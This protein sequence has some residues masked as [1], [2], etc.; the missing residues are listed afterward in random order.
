M[1]DRAE[2]RAEQLEEKDV[3]I[4]RLK[5]VI[6]SRVVGKL[7]IPAR[8]GYCNAVVGTVTWG[9]PPRKEEER[10]EAGS[11]AEADKDGTPPERVPEGGS[12]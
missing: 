9:D 3:E 7:E 5:G 12:E 1:Q 6:E 8:C 11:E 2:E 4:A 10:A